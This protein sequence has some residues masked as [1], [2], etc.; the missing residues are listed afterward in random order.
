MLKILYIDLF[1]QAYLISFLPSRPL[2]Q[3]PDKWSRMTER[4]YVSGTKQP[5]VTT[6]LQ[7]NIDLWYV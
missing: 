2:S 5:R 7:H 1:D 4:A 6:Q 3:S